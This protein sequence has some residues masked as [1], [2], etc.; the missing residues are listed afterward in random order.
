M[1]KGI[2]TLIFLLLIANFSLCSKG[3]D[4]SVGG[5]YGFGL[6]YSYDY[7]P[8]F[9]QMVTLPF[10]FTYYPGNGPY[11]SIGFKNKV[12]YGF[13]I[14]NDK[15]SFSSTNFMADIK[16]DKYPLEHEIYDNLSLLM[17][18]GGENCK[19]L[20]GLGAAMKYTFV[21][22]PDGTFDIS[23][24]VYEDPKINFFIIKPG[25]YQFFSM[26]PA[27]DFNLEVINKPKTFSFIVGTPFEFFIPFEKLKFYNI[28]SEIRGN[29]LYLLSK[30]ADRPYFNFSFGIEF[31]FSFYTYRNND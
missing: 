3:F 5:S 26:G 7:L 12:G 2:T 4:F 16:F 25:D 28:Y 20:F 17:K 11:F 22:I 27:F 21:N 6:N 23:G 13:T 8:G 18:F 1:K 31:I 30:Y 29:Y 10:I 15:K 19:F 24:T 14:Y 9:H